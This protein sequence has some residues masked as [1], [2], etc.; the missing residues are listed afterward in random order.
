MMIGWTR[1]R[2][3]RRGKIHAHIQSRRRR[4]CPRYSPAAA[5][6]VACVSWTRGAA[7][8]KSAWGP[9]TTRT[10]AGLSISSS[11][12]ATRVPL[13]AP[14][15][16]QS[17]AAAAAARGNAHT[18][19]AAA[20]STARTCCSHL[21]GDFL[22]LRRCR[23]CLMTSTTQPMGCFENA[24]ARGFSTSPVEART[25]K[26]HIICSCPGFKKKKL[27]PNFFE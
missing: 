11:G 25:F 23:A 8:T 22:Y 21:G 14:R 27:S 7:S 18:K 9:W 24:S 12:R 17:A 19:S 4:R 6:T 10:A 26:T 15:L 3:R 16:L 1:T 2:R 13:L 20:A 5:T